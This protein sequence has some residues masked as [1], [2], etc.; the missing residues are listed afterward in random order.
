MKIM[1][2]ILKK[3][4][5][6]M[7]LVSIISCK[8]TEIK[9]IPVKPKTE[10]IIIKTVPVKPKIENIVI[11]TIPVKPKTKSIVIKTVP[12]KSKT[13][14]SVDTFMNLPQIEN[15]SLG[16]KVLN[17]KTNKTLF[18]L[19]SDKSLVPAS[20]MKLLTTAAALEVLGKDYRFKTTLAYDGE[21]NSDGTLNGNIYVVGGGDPTLGSRYLVAKNPIWITTEEKQ[22]QLEFLNIWVEKIKT[23]GIKKINGK[24]ITDPSYYPK[25]TLS[26]TWEWGDLRYTFA[27]KPSGLTFLDN[28]IRLTL[29]KDGKDIK[30]SIYPNY[31]NTVVTNKVV[32]DDR[33]SS[34]ITLVVPPYTNEII[35][36]GTM[37]KPEISYNTVM[38]DPASALGEIFSQTLERKG[39]KNYGTISVDKVENKI[40]KKIFIYNQFSPELGEIIS[41]MNKYSINL[42]AEHLKIEVEKNSSQTIKKYWSKHLSTQ[43]LSIYDG[44][45][46]SRYDGVTP[47]TIVEVFKYMKKSKNFSSFYNSLAEPGKNGT[48]EDFQE[49]TVLIDNFHG[50]SGTLTGIK[51]YGGYMHNISGDMLAFSIII[52]HH[53]MSN[54]KISKELENLIKSIYYL[55]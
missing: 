29:S 50:K 17:L 43:G 22:K 16:I 48:L 24:I 7:V 13:E 15:A 4:V 44:S 2:K 46:L 49:K 40:S 36:L 37:N 8:N 45:G 11:K 53:G 19:N 10:N 1:K 51:A 42:F 38:Q 14:I 3:I 32:V 39:I 30:T 18:K 25:E 41:Y 20:N 35:A 9:T 47:D 27:S 5:L 52:N 12:V 55:K 54:S 31:T 28:S 33:N 34:Q 6:S 21:I 26:K 23:M